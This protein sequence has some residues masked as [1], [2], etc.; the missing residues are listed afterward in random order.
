MAI[1]PSVAMD[2]MEHEA[3]SV[4]KQFIRPIVNHKNNNVK[5]SH[6]AVSVGP[7]KD[8]QR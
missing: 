8:N 3:H 5:H 2:L 6:T 4:I 1:A 7:P